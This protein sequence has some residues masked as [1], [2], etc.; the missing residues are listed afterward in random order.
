MVVIFNH[1][2]RLV[3]SNDN[4][5]RS[6]RD[7]KNHGAVGWQHVRQTLPSKRKVTEESEQPRQRECVRSNIS[8]CREKGCCNRHTLYDESGRYLQH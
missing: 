5:H 3:V 8:P 2:F 4:Q 6:E 7:V 1:F